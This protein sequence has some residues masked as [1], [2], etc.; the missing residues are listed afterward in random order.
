M[1]VSNAFD[2]NPQH[3][4]TELVFVNAYSCPFRSSSIANAECVDAI[5]TLMQSSSWFEVR[6]SFCSSSDSPGCCAMVSS[7]NCLKNVSFQKD[8]KTLYRRKKV[9]RNHFSKVGVRARSI[10]QYRH[11]PMQTTAKTNST[12]SIPSVRTL[13]PFFIAAI[14]C[15]ISM[16]K[17]SNS[18][19]LNLFLS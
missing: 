16:C 14:R 9:Y 13:S 19:S 6:D 5:V 12:A 1:S 2:V 7:C 18:L 17:F 3:I 15:F 8:A 4:M 10:V 11:T